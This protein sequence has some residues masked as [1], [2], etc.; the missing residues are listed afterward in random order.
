METQ[1]IEYK[2]QWKDEFLKEICAFAN[3]QGGTLYV[4]IDDKGN[5]CGIN[6]ADT[7]LETLPNKITM[8]MGIVAAVNVLQ[9]DG[10]NYLQIV[11][12]PHPY[13]INYKGA[14][15]VRSGSTSQELKNNALNQFLLQKTRQDMGQCA[16]TISYKR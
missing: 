3:A 15:Y 8:T 5:V 12:E 6:N 4:G 9:K 2:S 11:T 1:N 14:Y 10:K 13:P 16:A 7:L